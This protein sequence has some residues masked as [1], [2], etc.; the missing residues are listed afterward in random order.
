M[1][2]DDT[3]SAHLLDHRRQLGQ[4]RTIGLVEQAAD[5]APCQPR[6]DD[7]EV[8]TDG[9]RH[10]RIELLPAGE[11]HEHETDHHARARPEVGDHV[12]AIGLDRRRM[13][14]APHPDEEEPEQRVGHP[15]ADHQH[16]PLVD[17]H[18][19]MAEPQRFGR[20]IQD[21]QRGEGDEPAFEAAGQ[22]LDLAVSIR[23][24]LVGRAAGECQARECEQC[25]DD[26]DDRLERI[27]EDRRRPGELVADELRREDER[28]DDQR[29]RPRPQAPRAIDNHR[30][31][32]C[33]HAM[34]IGDLG[35]AHARSSYKVRSDK[36]RHGTAS[37]CH[38]LRA[39]VGREIRDS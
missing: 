25:G 37:R 39:P 38:R 36:R 11:A 35:D 1:N 21:D 27:G 5:R 12:L 9:D 30:L 32:G 34:G 24:A 20:L 22:E 26:V 3:G 8:A 6:A 33:R 18:Q 19:L 4:Q 31:R 13:R 7:R 28:G 10:Q 29:N 15:G 14:A 2:G 16:E 23:V 17:R